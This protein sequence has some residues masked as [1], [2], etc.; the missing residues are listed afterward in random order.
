MQ[1]FSLKEAWRGKYHNDSAFTWSNNDCS[2]QSSIDFWLVSDCLH[3]ADISVDIHPTL[4][5]D[6]KADYITVEWLCNNESPNR[7]AYWILNRS[8]LKMDTVNHKIGKLIS[9]LFNKAKYENWERF[10]FVTAK[11]LRKYGCILNKSQKAE[12]N[13]IIDGIMSLSK[14]ILLTFPMKIEQLYQFYKTSLKKSIKKGQREP[15]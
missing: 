1:R 8:L 5:T 12:E 7:K 15:L 11:F 13:R 2:K 4:L 10:K 9:F 14:R 3:A 6:H